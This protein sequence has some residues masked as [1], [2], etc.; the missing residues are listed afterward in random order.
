MVK[1]LTKSRLVSMKDRHTLAV[2]SR[3][4]E[5]LFIQICPAG[6][7]RRLLVS[8]LSSNIEIH[9]WQRLHSYV[10]D[11]RVRIRHCPWQSGSSSMV[12]HWVYDPDFPSEP[13]REPSLYTYRT[14]LTDVLST[15]LRRPRYFSPAVV[16]LM[17]NKVTMR[18][19]AQKT[20][21][22]DTIWAFTYA[23]NRF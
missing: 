13:Y 10:A 20:N 12:R 21:M 8:G 19:D 9:I 15:F 3:D 6:I 4:V 17:V 7:N 22:L 14:L 23:K 2:T 1:S 5:D 11:D 18:S 16:R